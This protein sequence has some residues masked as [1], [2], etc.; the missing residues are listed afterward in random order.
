GVPPDALQSPV[1]VLIDPRRPISTRSRRPT[2]RGASPSASGPPPS[3][4][5]ESLDGRRYCSCCDVVGSAPRHLE[6]E[7]YARMSS[8]R[9]P[10]VLIVLSIGAGCS[11]GTAT[12]AGAGPM[13]SGR[14]AAEIKALYEARADSARMRFTPADVAFMTGMIAH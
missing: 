12:D 10:V 5:L 6:V 3:K 8:F 1:P 13:P 14:S 9:F 2:D 4:P 11:A 7:R